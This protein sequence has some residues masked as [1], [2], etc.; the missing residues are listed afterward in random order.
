LRAEYQ[1]VRDRFVANLGSLVGGEPALDM[2]S[3]F[4]V[5]DGRRIVVPYLTVK[6]NE[7]AYAI[8][9]RESLDNE[10]VGYVLDP[11]P[12]TLVTSL[13][14]LRSTELI[15]EMLEDPTVSYLGSSPN[16]RYR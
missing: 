12:T 9:L 14:A 5:R 11:F 10:S 4:S 13:K 2:D 3:L 16:S 7:V 15:N 6:G 1:A 8:N